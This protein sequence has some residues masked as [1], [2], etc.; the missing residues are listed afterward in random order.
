MVSISASPFAASASASRGRS[1][2]AQA[3]ADGPPP[4]DRTEEEDTPSRPSAVHQAPAFSSSSYAALFQEQAS[5]L[6]AAAQG[7]DGPKDFPTTAPAGETPV[8]G[9]G[10]FLSSRDRAM[11]ESITGHH[12]DERNALVDDKGQPVSGN[13]NLIIGQMSV[14]RQSGADLRGAMTPAYMEKLAGRLAAH[15]EPLDRSFID[16]AIQYLS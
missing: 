1:T 15:G 11:I 7:A 4:S 13:I 3:V 6:S 14:D 2:A 5:R 16:K 12:F 10:Y 9:M 8:A